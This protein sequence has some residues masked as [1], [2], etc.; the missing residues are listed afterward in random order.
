SLFSCASAVVPD[1]SPGASVIMAVWL[2]SLVCKI[3]NHSS[4]LLMFVTSMTEALATNFFGNRDLRG[5]RWR[6]ARRPRRNGILAADYADIADRFGFNPVPSAKSAVSFLLFH[7]Q[8]TINHLV[9]VVI[10]V[11]LWPVGTA[12][13]VTSIAIASAAEPLAKGI[14][15]NSFL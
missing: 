5:T 1:E 4:A 8:S 6:M 9:S 13:C 11:H 7:Q 15:D 14:Q 10:R 12:L 3:S 2:R